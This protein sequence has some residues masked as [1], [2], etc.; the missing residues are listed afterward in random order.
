MKINAR[1][2]AGIFYGE[3][4]GILMIL[5]R[6]YELTLVIILVLGNN[7]ISFKISPLKWKYA[8]KCILQTITRFEI[9]L[10]TKKTTRKDISSCPT[11]ILYFTIKYYQKSLKIGP[12]TS[13]LN[14]NMIIVNQGR[15]GYRKVHRGLTLNEERQI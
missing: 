1:F 6:E 15:T 14:Y 13:T 12:Q 8:C 3:I 7:W 10:F 2:F 11:R 4:E 5:F 9:R